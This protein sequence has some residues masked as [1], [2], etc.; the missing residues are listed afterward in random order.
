MN[1][2]NKNSD[3]QM[4]IQIDFAQTLIYNEI[5]TKILPICCFL[6]TIFLILLRLLG[7]LAQLARAF[8]WQSRGHRFDSDMLHTDNQ[9]VT[10]FET[11]NPFYFARNLPDSYPS[12]L[13]TLYTMLKNEIIVHIKYIT[14]ELVIQLIR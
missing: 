6:L 1:L 10:V 12:Y 3:L 9:R 13:H 11:C 14:N 2:G 7:A 5:A 4:I 8:D